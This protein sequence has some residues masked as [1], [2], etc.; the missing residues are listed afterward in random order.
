M[1]ETLGHGRDPDMLLPRIAAGDPD[2]TE[3]A[4]SRFGA[5]IRRLARACRV[6]RADLD[7]AVQEV[8]L[9]L[10][11]NASRFDPTRAS[12]STFV[13]LVARRRL[14]DLQRHRARRLDPDSLENREH[15][16]T[17]AC[18]GPLAV[19]AREEL[20]KV[21]RLLPALG[22]ASREIMDLR[23]VDGL[24]LDAIALRL[25]MPIGTVKSLVRRT[26]IR[27]RDRL[28]VEPSAA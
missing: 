20:S 4:Y 21:R 17:G 13:A 26:L 18:A 9:K 10:W 3:L 22:D 25:D 19:E 7:D 12:E 5:S 14:I 6:P 15:D 1:N 24:S 28:G 16:A 8:M 27:M 11:Q 2:A 23:Y